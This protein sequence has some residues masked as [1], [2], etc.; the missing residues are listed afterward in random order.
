MDYIQTRSPI[1]KSEMT[2]LIEALRAVQKANIDGV[3]LSNVVRTC[4]E[5]GLKKAELID[6]S[7]E[8]VSKGGKVKDF[9]QVGDSS[10][11]LTE[12]AKMIIQDHIEYLKEKGYRR[13][14][15]SPLFP[16]KDRGPYKSRT[17]DNHL[18]DAQDAEI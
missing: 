15:S 13:Y 12:R 18:K 1:P 6:L 3:V 14:P 10:F 9:M 16:A 4:H 7:I 17:L 11:R 5:C 2:H 8:D